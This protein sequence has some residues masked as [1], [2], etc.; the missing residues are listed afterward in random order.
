MQPLPT[1]YGVV[2]AGGV[3]TRFWPL[4]NSKRP[5]QFIDVLGVGRT[6][7]QQTVERLLPIVPVEQMLVMTGEPFAHLVQEQLPQL[8]PNQI[9]A[10]PC[11]RNTAPC[12]AYAAYKILAT[13]PNAL[14][15]VTPADHYI[16]DTG[17]YRVL[18]QQAAEHCSK[19]DI[20]MTIGIEPTYPAT[21]FGYI[22]LSDVALAGGYGPIVRFKEKPTLAEAEL[23]LKS[24]R[25][26]WNSGMFVWK[27][28]SIA[29]ALETYLPEVACHFSG[30][31]SYGTPQEMADV[32]QAFWNCPS[33][34]VD[35]G[36]MEKAKN[37]HVIRGE[38]G[39]DD[40]GTW[41]ALERHQHLAKGK[42]EL[43]DSKGTL[44]HTTQP[45]KRIV[46]AGLTNYLVVDT[47]DALLIAPKDD[48]AQLNTLIQELAD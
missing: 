30:I 43:L 9:L 28:Q 22:E 6:L 45:E 27:A 18:L 26:V 23:L 3:G 1:I 34:S 21:G 11:R 36:V 8:L 40:L 44:V 42:V 16:A 17:T 46:V 15:V 47:G 41:A 31:T 2:M 29:H 20:L 32:Q 12:I 25:Y 38:F 48:E 4:S 33:I 35:F 10:E 13:N 14:M 7:L 39:W 24:G 19:D 37:V 5:K